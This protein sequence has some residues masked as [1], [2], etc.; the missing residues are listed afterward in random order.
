MPATAEGNSFGGECI[1]GVEVAGADVTSVRKRDPARG[2]GRLAA[3]PV[4]GHAVGCVRHRLPA[5]I[6]ASV[7]RRTT[8]STMTARPVRR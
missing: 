1:G 8:G 2:R 7:S 5:A 6:K 3:Q 4:P